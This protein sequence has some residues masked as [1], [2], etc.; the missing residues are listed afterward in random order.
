MLCPGLAIMRLN[1]YLARAGLGSRRKC[2]DLIKSGDIRINGRTV[3]ELA[4]RVGPSDKVTCCGKL[5]E[6]ESEFT[7]A[8]HK[9]R[10]VVCSKQAQANERTIF[11]LLPTSW[12][13]VFYVGRLDKA[14]EGLI[15][16]T[17]DGD[18]AQ[19]LTHPKYKLPKTYEVTLNKT[20][21]MDLAEKLKK[22]FIIEGK[23]ARADAVQQISERAI[24]IVL[25][26][27]IKRQIREMLYYIGYDVKKLVR[28]RIGQLN[29]GD[30]PPGKWRQ[31][32]GRDR[33]ALLPPAKK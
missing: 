13:R 22:G 7:V 30:L 21:N 33:A 31:L 3:G 26:Q 29:L 23:R 24:R 10:G 16:L 9:P 20:F 8:F 4:T 5:V 17:N 27:G 11:D 19:Q 18:F 12:P 6:V 25:T 2:E 15:I 32:T 1:Q 14:S 28:T